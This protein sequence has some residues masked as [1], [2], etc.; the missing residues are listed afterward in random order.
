MKFVRRTGLNRKS[1]ELATSESHRR[2][3]ISIRKHTKEQLWA[4]STP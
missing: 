3:H 2:K 1:G 4:Y